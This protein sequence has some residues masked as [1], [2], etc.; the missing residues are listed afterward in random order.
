MQTLSLTISRY[1]NSKI[2]VND[3]DPKG[4]MF[5]V[6]WTG[7]M[8][9]NIRLLLTLALCLTLFL[10]NATVRIQLMTLTLTLQGFLRSNISEWPCAISYH[11]F[12]NT[13]FPTCIIFEIFYFVDIWLNTLTLRVKYFSFLDRPYAT[14]NVLG[15]IL[16]ETLTFRQHIEQ[17][18]VHGAASSMYALKV[19]RS[20]GLSGQLL[21]D[22]TTQTLVARMLHASPVWWGSSMQALIMK[23]RLS[24]GDW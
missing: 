19:L 18:V 16:D 3:L 4:Q 10:R 13:N 15:V 2:L 5:Q 7:H 14:L 21:W 12:V 22:V 23:L 11:S 6:F 20:R 1:C 17:R 9:L 24:F 8:Q